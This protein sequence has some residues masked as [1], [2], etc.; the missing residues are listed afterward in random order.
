LPLI[1]CHPRIKLVW[2]IALSAI[3]LILT[4]LLYQMTIESLKMLDEV[5]RTFQ[6]I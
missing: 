1:W 5:Q 6:G 2:E 4:W 3:V